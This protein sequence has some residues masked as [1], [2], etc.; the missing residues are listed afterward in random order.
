MKFEVH[1]QT[2]HDGTL[3]AWECFNSS[4]RSFVYC[5]SLSDHFSR[6]SVYFRWSAAGVCPGVP[7]PFSRATH[8]LL[9]LSLTPRTSGVWS[10][11]ITT[12]RRIQ[13]DTARQIQT[14]TH[15]WTHRRTDGRIDRR[16]DGYDILSVSAIRY[17]TCSWA[18]SINLCPAGGGGGG[19][20]HP[21]VFRK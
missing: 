18:M 3:Q 4:H 10:G 1:K 21:V 8:R 2:K 12:D 19:K 6:C 14:D 7:P 11:R 17:N 15:S 20:G 5:C 13:T 16:T 9:W